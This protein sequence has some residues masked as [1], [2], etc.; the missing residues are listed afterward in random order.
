MT[1]AAIPTT[2]SAF[3]TDPFFALGRAD[4]H[5]EATHTPLEGITAHANLLLDHIT[6]NTGHGQRLYTAGYAHRAA[7]LV[8]EHLAIVNAESDLAQT[9]LDRKQGRSRSTRHTNRPSRAQERAA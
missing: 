9:W 3:S 1:T 5:D 7:E 8:A 2:N 4:A 6:P